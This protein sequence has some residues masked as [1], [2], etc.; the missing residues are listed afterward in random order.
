MEIVPIDRPQRTIGTIV[1]LRREVSPEREW[2]ITELSSDG[3]LVHS[4]VYVHHEKT[5]MLNIVDEDEASPDLWVWNS[6]YSSDA[7]ETILEREDEE[8]EEEEVEEE[9]DEDNNEEGAAIEIEDEEE[10][11]QGKG[12]NYDLESSLCYSV[13]RM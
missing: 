2:E 1:F 7:L 8:E 3:D 13:E 6:I 11:E 4:E 5:L 9:E 10:E 12:E